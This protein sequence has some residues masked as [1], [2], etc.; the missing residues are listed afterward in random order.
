MSD[1]EPLKIEKVVDEP[2]VKRGFVSRRDKWQPLID[3]LRILPK[4]KML[5]VDVSHFSA[6]AALNRYGASKL[7]KKI[8]RL[9]DNKC[10]VVSANS[11]TENKPSEEPKTVGDL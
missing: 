7:F 11:F 4:G 6:R 5:V 1:I 3:A 2:P 9:E 8:I 10:G